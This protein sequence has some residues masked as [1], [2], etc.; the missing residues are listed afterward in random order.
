MRHCSVV[1]TCSG[2]QTTCSIPFLPLPQLFITKNPVVAEHVLFSVVHWGDFS[3]LYLP[4]S[5]GRVEF[6]SCPLGTTSAAVYLGLGW[7]GGEVEAAGVPWS[8]QVC[9]PPVHVPTQS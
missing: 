9:V 8:S 3:P 6:Q 4:L 2:C 5:S 7:C 1:H